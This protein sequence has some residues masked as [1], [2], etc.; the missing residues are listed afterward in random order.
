MHPSCCFFLIISLQSKLARSHNRD[1]YYLFMFTVK[2]K[3]LF[4]FVVGFLLC[5]QNG[6]SGADTIESVSVMEGDPVTLN[7][8]VKT[9]Q[10]EDM[11]WYFNKTLLAHISR[12]RYKL[13]AVDQ[14]KERFRDRLKLDHQTGS[15]TITH[16]TTEDS[17]LY[18]QVRIINSSSEKVFNLTVTAV[19]GS[20]LSSA[21]VAGIVVGVLLGFAAAAGT[22]VGIYYRKRHRRQKDIEMQEKREQDTANG[23][24]H[25]QTDHLMK[26]TANGTPHSQTD[27]LMKDTANGTPHSQTDH[28]MKD[29]TNGTPYS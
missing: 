21:A 3:V 28:L 9:N 23:T 26:D 17:G 12:D 14:C 16:T 4:C 18:T 8:S 27:H 6:A 22:A 7:S 10:Q 5:H 1:F 15:L 11:K 20:G 25:S 29:T 19:P 2:M 24:P 13:C